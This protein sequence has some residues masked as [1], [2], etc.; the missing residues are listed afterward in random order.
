MMH[1]LLPTFCRYH[2]DSGEGYGIYTVSGLT[3]MTKLQA[4]LVVDSKKSTYGSVIGYFS[5]GSWTYDVAI[6]QWYY[7]GETEGIVDFT[8][9]YDHYLS[10]YARIRTRVETVGTS[11]D[12]G[13][14]LEIGGSYD[15]TEDFGFEIFQ[16]LFPAIGI[17]LTDELSWCRP[18]LWLWLFHN[19]CCSILSF[20]SYFP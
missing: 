1:D 18:R 7:G 2:F 12:T 8:V 15:A 19:W 10:P 9:S 17:G 11:Q 16:Y 20:R 4:V 14:V 13:S 3:S 5:V 6:Q